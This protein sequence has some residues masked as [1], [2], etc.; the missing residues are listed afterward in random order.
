[1]SEPD[2]PIIAICRE[3]N[4][5]TGERA[6]YRLDGR[7]TNDMLFMLRIRQMY[8]PELRYFATREENWEECQSEIEFFLKKRDISREMTEKIGLVEIGR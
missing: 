2:V 6:V 8:N 3:I 7:A 4:T 1:M 5:R